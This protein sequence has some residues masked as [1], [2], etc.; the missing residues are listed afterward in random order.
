MPIIKTCLPTC[1]GGF[2]REHPATTTPT[3]ASASI[4]I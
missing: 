1:R 2:S 3:P 4:R